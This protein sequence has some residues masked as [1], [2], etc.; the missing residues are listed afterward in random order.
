[1]KSVLLSTLFLLALTV[2]EHNTSVP[3]IPPATPDETQEL[4]RPLPNL[5]VDLDGQPS[6][7]GPVMLY[8]DEFVVPLRDGITQL[9]GG[10]AALEVGSDKAWLI[11]ANGHTVARIPSAANENDYKATIYDAEGKQTVRTINMADHPAEANVPGRGPTTM[12]DVDLLAACLG[13]TVD[14]NNRRMSLFTPNYWCAKLKIDPQRAAGRQIKEIPLLPDFGISPPA[15]TILFWVRPPVKSYVQVFFLG[16]D[17]PQPLLAVDN[18]GQPVEIPER[19]DDPK[20]REAAADDPIRAECRGYGDDIGKVATYVA[21]ILN[22]DI[23]DKDPI[24]AINGGEVPDDG[25]A[26]IA[27]RQRFDPMP[28][29]FDTV[30]VKEGE[31]DPAKFAAHHNTRVEIVRCVNGI[32]P[33]EKL[34]VGAP[35]SV[36]T[37]VDD[38]AM[39]ASLVASYK[40]VGQ[41][42]VLP[43]E[44][45]ENLAQKWGVTMDEFYAGNTMVPNGG[46]PDPGDLINEIRKRSYT[47]PASPNPPTERPVPFTGIAYLKTAVD[48]RQS[49]QAGTASV[50]HIDGSHIVQVSEYMEAAKAYKIQYGNL[51]GYVDASALDL[52]GAH[53]LGPTGGSD[54][55]SSKVATEAVK[56]LGTKYVWGGDGLTT[57]IDCSHFVAQVY[58][59]IGWPVPPAPV[60]EQERIGDIV[61]F[62]PGLSRRNYREIRLPDARI[63]PRGTSDISKLQ[64][65]DRIIFQHGN[66]DAS[67]SRHTAIYIGRVPTYLRSRFGDIQY[68]FVH[69]SCS[70]GVTISGLGEKYYWGIYHYTVRSEPT[71]TRTDRL[72]SVSGDK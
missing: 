49:S 32:Q 20:V 42:E 68:A 40:I 16:E 9:S 46:D 37:S 4:F 63:A 72:A 57:G 17:A 38:S 27:V 21:L 56:Y 39:R 67:G 29:K 28:V 48:L 22:V 5:V 54:P 69:A 12:I 64:P 19:T 3:P 31:E 50:G 14:T 66:T 1:M 15:R 62:K 47:P 34:K 10:Q 44:N 61:H 24:Q 25:W 23:G 52:R 30:F 53:A 58:Q 13:V 55:S 43:G 7:L 45:A 71:A 36:I 59:R 51:M 26:V 65:G 2:L 11:K 35:L 70:R 41:Y 33:R 6:N 18:S 8:F 60:V